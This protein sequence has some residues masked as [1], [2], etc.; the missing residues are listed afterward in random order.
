MPKLIYSSEKVGC[1][2]TIELDNGE[3]CSVSVAQVGVLVKTIKKGLLAQFFG[4]KLYNEEVLHNAAATGMALNILYPNYAVNVRF[5]NPILASFTNAIWHCSTAAEVSTVLNTAIDA[6][7][8]N[9]ALADQ[10]V[11]DTKTSMKMAS[12]TG[13][14]STTEIDLSVLYPNYAV[15]LVYDTK[16]SPEMTLDMA[17]KAIDRYGELMECQGTA[18]IDVSKLPLPK[19]QM[20]MALMIGWK[21]TNDQRIKAAIEHGFVNLSHYQENIGS[22]SIDCVFSP[23]TDAVKDLLLNKRWLELSDASRIETDAL[24][25]EWQNFLRK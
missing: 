8:I 11:D 7:K 20:K 9:F 12:K 3:I 10:L 2:A 18:F 15:Q 16:T 19:T 23:N 14:K 1:G 24:S 21:N 6:T 5:K 13:W 22:N 17:I 25:I 4:A